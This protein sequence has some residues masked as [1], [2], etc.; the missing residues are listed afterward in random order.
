MDINEKIKEVIKRTKE[1]TKHFP[2]TDK[3]IYI[4]ALCYIAIASIDNDITDLL[5][6]V[7]SKVYIFF[8][9]KKANKFIKEIE[10]REVLSYC[11]AHTKYEEDGCEYI[12]INT[13]Q[14]PKN[15]YYIANLFIIAIHE[16]KHAMNCIINTHITK[17]TGEY[18]YSGLNGRPNGSSVLDEAFNYYLTRIYLIQLF[19]LK[20]ENEITHPE[21]KRILDSFYIN[22]RGLFDYRP[23]YLLRKLFLD[24]KFFILLYNAALY[25]DLDSFYGELARITE[26]PPS[27]V[28]EFF[29]EHLKKFNNTGFMRPNLSK[30]IN[31]I[32]NNCPR[33]VLKI[34]SSIEN[35]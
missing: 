22:T 7:F 14:I 1:L 28:E 8:N 27:G 16:I 13:F 19:N 5:D 26:L 23:A 3:E 12:I 6:E 31:K 15:K 9:N 29:I 17:P 34:K 25:R 2:Y 24:E 18:V 30:S 21:I 33:R 20:E 11:G 4:L 35:I 10:G 32:N